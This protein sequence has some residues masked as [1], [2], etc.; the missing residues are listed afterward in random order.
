MHASLRTRGSQSQTIGVAL[1]QFYRM[2]LT[3]LE[4]TK[5]HGHI[6]DKQ[7]NPAL[8]GLQWSYFSANSIFVLNCTSPWTLILPNSAS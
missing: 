4:V 7:F 2:K 1:S 3:V 6:L 8:D 5:I